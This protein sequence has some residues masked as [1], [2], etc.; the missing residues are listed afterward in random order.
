MVLIAH[1]NHETAE[2][3]ELSNHLLNVGRLAAENG[4]VIKHEETLYLIGILH[5]LGKADRR[6]QE[7]ITQKPSMKVKHAAAGAKYF[8]QYI[9]QKYDLKGNILKEDYILFGEYLDVISYVILSHHGLFD[10]FS[11]HSHEN[12]LVY[13]MEYDERKDEGIYYFEEDVV[14]FA[15]EFFQENDVDLSRL[16]TDSFKEFKCLSEKLSSIDE[17]EEHF[18]SGLKVRLY[19]SIL[20]N[21]DITDTINA[22]REEV[23]SLSEEDLEEK[24]EHYMK[25]VEQVYAGF[26]KPVT[27]IDEVRNRLAVEARDRGRTDGP[28]IY[29]LNLPTGAGKTLLSLRYGVHQM[30]HQN[31]QRL[32]Y[33][34][35]FLSVLEQNAEE[36]KSI[37]KDKHIT[38]HHSNMV[39]TSEEGET[40]VQEDTRENMLFQY[41]MDSW[42]SPMI[43]STMVQFFQTLFKEKSNN[44]RR[45][46]S[47]ANSVII[48]DEVQSLPIE[49]TH[50]FNMMMNFISQVMDSVIIL[51]TATQPVY[52]S[53]YIKYQID[54]QHRNKKDI[55]KMN[56]E[57]RKS[58]D[59]TTVSKLNQ[60]ES[61]DEE[62]ITEEILNH[63]DD[64][65]LVILNTKK[66]VNK[67]VEILKAQT[68]RP[69]YYLSTNLCPEHR[70]DIIREIKEKLPTE[71]VIC[72]STQLIEAGVDIDFKRLIRS[73]A[74]I[75]S[76][77][78]S[79]GR[80][81]RNGK[82][83][84]K[85]QVKL[86]KT[87]K[88]FENIDVS[89]LK[90][91]K[92]K[93]SVTERILRDENAEINITELN[94]KF[95]ESYFANASE[96]L[97]YSFGKDMGTAVDLLSE[98]K[99]LALP[100]KRRY[101]NQSFK[102]AGQMI[103]L[104]DQETIPVIVYYGESKEIIEELI[105]MLER[106]ETEYNLEEIDEIKKI[107]NQLQLYTVNL[108]NLEKLGQAIMSYFDGS[109]NILI[110]DN[111]DEALGVIEE[112]SDFVT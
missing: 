21:A 29:R 4:S 111:Y 70:K 22:Y 99:Y 2:E 48:L 86:V 16:I 35:P 100:S 18:Y 103:N 10:I 37:L 6:F 19:L 76:I 27:E 90:S 32:I 42:D 91:I 14:K 3:Q 97:N 104:I 56:E 87:K 49:V 45:F 101:L 105:P 33:I 31:K 81:N 63:P 47:L 57:E 46:S 98:N 74:G 110:E 96:N 65:T 94:D 83:E 84:G 36:I 53:D 107:L 11:T 23:E 13:R 34:T 72:V 67:V 39:R 41:M 17:T 106:V 61:S 82:L 28:G 40:G 20:K 12:Q 1:K 30:K 75:D 43:L 68:S 26:S 59:R 15:N 109:I 112:A 62:E 102:S 85:G 80:C 58:F 60:G 89:A 108:Y 79:M 9:K 38:E 78:Q 50:L 44:I 77:V 69:V 51:C 52:D 7:K 88:E 95:Y 54:Y 25:A 73:Y 66:A 64:S 8:N 5:D 92:E 24:K 71:P 55:V 93:V